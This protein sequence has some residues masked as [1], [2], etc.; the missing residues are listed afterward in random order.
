MD[1]I[2]LDR[3]QDLAGFVT[4]NV[5]KGKTALVLARASLTSD[6]PE[7]YTYIEQVSNMFL[8]K[9]RPINTTFQFLVLIHGDLSADL[10]VNNFAVAIEIAAKKDIRKG[11]VVRKGDIADIR[12]LKFPD[13]R[14]VETDKVICSFKVG[15]KFALFFDLTREN[16]LDV[17][18]M[19]LALGRL[20]CYLSFQHVYNV[21]ESQMQFETMTKDGWFPFIEIIG[22]EYESLSKGYESGFH[23]EN[24][25]DKVVGSFD[26]AR[27]ERIVK[28]WWSNQI[29]RD[30]QPL[31]EAGVDAYLRGDNKDHINCISTLLPQI[32]GILRL[33]YLT[34]TGKGRR[35]GTGDLLEYLLKRGTE[36]SGSDYS[37]FLPVPFFDYLKNGVFAGFDLEDGRVDLSRHSLAHGVAKALDYTETRALQ[38][39]LVL[40]Q[41]Y[42]YIHH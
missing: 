12:R 27:I 14:I 15:W 4:G 20:Y 19:S 29:F 8:G 37:L 40:D 32:E 22:N 10:Y 5:E 26:R 25:I 6:D 28:K 41:I 18:E 33:E 11:E 35:V 38:V 23:L 24:T 7:F 34:E 9:F 13:I 2:H 30:K 36:K 42:F 16:R 17:D 1:Q 21:L 31:L 39:I 3:V